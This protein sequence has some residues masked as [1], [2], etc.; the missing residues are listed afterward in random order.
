MSAS[1]KVVIVTGG[2][3]GIGRAICERLSGDGW[4]V[5]C[6]DI[7]EQESRDTAALVGSDPVTCDVGNEDGV[8][9][10]VRL[11]AEKYGRL[12]GIVSNA[13]V[14]RFEPLADWTLAQWDRIIATNLTASFLLARASEKLLRSAKGAM[15]LMTSTRAHMSEPGTFAYSASKGGIV[16]LTHSL[17]MSLQPDVR[18][19]C[20]APG[21]IDTGK[22]P[23]E[24]G[25]HEQH[26][27][28]RVGRPE[29]IAAATAFLLDGEQ[30]GFMTGQEMVVDGGMTK[31][32]IYV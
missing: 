15:V 28:G 13:G 21:W 22:H 2:A 7:E 30:S 27:V 32:M 20:I 3:R 26:P 24:P 9:S 19:N 14:N 29:D 5:V 11:V 23:I 31:K 16:A 6:V 17:A 4:R 10:L 12:D 25:D 1:S 8:E 18:V